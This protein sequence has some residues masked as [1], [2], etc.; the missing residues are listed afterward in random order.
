[1]CNL[2]LVFKDFNCSEI[3][4]K[5]L[6]PRNCKDC[7]HFERKKDSEEK[8]NIE[9]NNKNEEMEE[10]EE[11]E[12]NL[13]NETE[14]ELLEI[15]KPYKCYCGAKFDTAGEFYD[16]ARFCDTFQRIQAKEA[17]GNLWRRDHED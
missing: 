13:T 10:E 5:L 6:K 9:E 11:I 15:G 12:L 17:K 4:Q 2:K 16:H 8:S 7:N 1:M 14:N 3:G